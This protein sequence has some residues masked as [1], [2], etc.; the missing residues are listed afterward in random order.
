LTNLLIVADYTKFAGQ[1][2]YLCKDFTCFAFR[3]E[4]GRRFSRMNAD[5]KAYNLRR[6]EC[7]K[8]DPNR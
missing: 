8:G 7:S 6:S 1:L 4:T 5:L 2:I 3:K